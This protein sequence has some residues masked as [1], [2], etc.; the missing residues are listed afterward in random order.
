MP[1]KSRNLKKLEHMVQY[2]TFE[3]S[4]SEGPHEEEPGLFES[5]AL[6]FDQKQ[7]PTSSL[8]N[9]KKR[10]ERL[11]RKQRKLR[12]KIT[13]LENDERLKRQRV[14]HKHQD[15]VL[16]FDASV[17]ESVLEYLLRDKKMRRVDTPTKLLNNSNEFLPLEKIEVD[18]R[19]KNNNEEVLL[20]P[21]RE[22]EELKQNLEKIMK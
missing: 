10:L 5:E 12:E 18:L 11:K 19:P 3:S 17:R 1:E 21:R 9:E 16:T 7:N 22:M 2:E 4:Q 20:T 13:Q 15:D 8:E 14:R 6:S